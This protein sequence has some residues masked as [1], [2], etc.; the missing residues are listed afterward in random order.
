IGG[1]KKIL[2]SVGEF[3]YAPEFLR[4]GTAVHDAFYPSRI[5]IGGTNELAL[6][7][8]ELLSK[9]VLNQP[10]IILTNYREAECIKLFSN[11]YLAMRIAFFNELDTFMMNEN[12]DSRTIIHGMGLDD[13]I[14]LFYNNPSFGFGGYCLPKDTEEVI[15]SLNTKLISQINN[16]NSYR[17]ENII[18]HILK[19]GYKKIGVYK[20]SS[21][22]GSKGIRNSSTIILID[23]LKK[24]GIEIYVYDP[25]NQT[26]N[27]W[28]RVESTK[29]L[30]EITDIVIANRIDDSI[31]KYKDKIF[32]RDIFSC[33]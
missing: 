7:A 33:N 9:C 23:A 6:K 17:I 12:L 24:H 27:D 20:L 1:S 31:K 13:R 25:E 18:N 14:G 11:T 10:E 8:S 28:I 22:T 26:I 2:D 32:T 3:I 4:E 29:K 15:N 30:F 16:S 21:K 19:C 5:I